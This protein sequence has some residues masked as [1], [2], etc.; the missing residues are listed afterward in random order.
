MEPNKIP[1]CQKRKKRK[2]REKK[3]KK[4]PAHLLVT[5][6]EG[7]WSRPAGPEGCPISLHSSTSLLHG[8]DPGRDLALHTLSMSR[9]AG[10]ADSK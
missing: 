1:I 4:H 10:A 3:G 8:M 7:T 6:L 9:G 5:R 2:K